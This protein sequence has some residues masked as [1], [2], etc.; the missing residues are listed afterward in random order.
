M[1]TSRATT[2][3]PLLLGL[4]TSIAA[5][6][7]TTSLTN[8]KSPATL[9][10]QCAATNLYYSPNTPKYASRSQPLAKTYATMSSS[11]DKPTTPQNPSTPEQAAAAAPASE[12]AGEQK[13]PILALPDS[14][15]ASELPQL[16]VNGDGVKLDHLGPLVVNTDGTLARIS[17]WA[18]MTE[19]ERQNTLRIIGKRNKQRMEKLKAEQAEQEKGGEQ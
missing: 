3:L 14:S 13:K 4:R 8:L 6:S 7:T 18:G 11:S 2:L 19:M 5:T 17:N 9:F 16:D 12:A 1:R 10:A 15:T